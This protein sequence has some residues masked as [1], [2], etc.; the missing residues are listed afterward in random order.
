MIFLKDHNYRIVFQVG[1]NALAFFCKIIEDTE[2]FLTFE[3]KFKKTLTYNKA[4]IISFEEISN[5]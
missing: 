1:N 3:D 4:N 5:G 2:N